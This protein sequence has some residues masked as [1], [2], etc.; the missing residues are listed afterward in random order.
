MTKQKDN[1][2]LSR[3]WAREL[4]EEENNEVQGA[5]HTTTKCSGPTPTNPSP[6]GD[7]GECGYV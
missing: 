7:R 5:I 3:I 2:V 6:D 4:T 1:R